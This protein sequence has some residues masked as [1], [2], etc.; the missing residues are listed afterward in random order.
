MEPYGPDLWLEKGAWPYAPLLEQPLTVYK[1]Y[2]MFSTYNYNT[3]E[4]L[5]IV[6]GNDVTE[7]VCNQNYF[8]HYFSTHLSSASALK[9]C[10]FSLTLYYG[11]VRF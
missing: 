7:I 8:M 11:I 6:Y 9:I 2:H 5:D 4:L 10:A 3:R 1:K